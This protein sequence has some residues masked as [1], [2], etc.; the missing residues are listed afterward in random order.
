MENNQTENVSEETTNLLE[1]ESVLLNQ[2]EYAST[3]QRFLNFVIDNLLMNYGLS[4][5]TGFA[6]AIVITTFF[7]EMVISIRE[8]GTSFYILVYFIAVVNY[9]FYYT[10]CEKIFNGYTLGKLITGTR[11]IRE[12]GTALTFKNA[13]MRTLIRLV[14]FEAFS[15][16]KIRPWHDEWSKTMVIRSR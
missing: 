13:F 4:Y 5:L 9:L 7:P 12:D 15:G 2:F 1:D 8:R 3:G 10:L 14:P 16:F 6:V 11:A